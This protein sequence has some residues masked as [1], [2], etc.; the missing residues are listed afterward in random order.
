MAAALPCPAQGQG[1]NPNKPVLSTTVSTIRTELQK[2]DIVLCGRFVQTNE[3]CEFHVAQVLRDHPARVGQKVLPLNQKV[4]NR[5]PNALWIVTLSA[6]DGKLE[7]TARFGGSNALVVYFDE[8]LR[9]PN[10]RAVQSRFFSNHLDHPDDQIANDAF[11]EMDNHHID[12]AWAKQFLAPKLAKWLQDPLVDNHR[13]ELY[14]RLLAKCGDPKTHGDLLGALFDDPKSGMWRS[15][16]AVF[17]Y[18]KFQPNQAWV[19]IQK[20]LNNR[21][22]EHLAQRVRLLQLVC[23]CY[24]HPEYGLNKQQVLQ[25]MGIMLDDPETAE[26]AVYFVRELKA[27]EMTD[28]V[29]ALNSQKSH[30]RQGVH[31]AILEFALAN[32]SPR[33]AEFVKERWQRDPEL[34]R[35]MA[36]SPNRTRGMDFSFGGFGIEF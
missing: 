12:S 15:T 21:K 13:F 2:A 6:K 26:I 9:L 18:L 24:N 3:I 5:A 19:Y 11:L 16:E 14:V 29:L 1:A 20:V 31:V 23:S 8:I 10:D 34:F 35:V 4:S 28:R 33:A 25:G 36:G 22:E 32:P 17:A 30:D 27:W 7:F